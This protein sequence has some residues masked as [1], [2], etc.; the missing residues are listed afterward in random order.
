MK[1]KEYEEGNFGYIGG[2]RYERWPGG[3]AGDK[4]IYGTSDEPIYQTQQINP[5]AYKFDVED[6]KYEVTLRFAEI[7]TEKDAKKLLYNL[8]SDNTKDEAIDRIFN[9]Y[10]NGE[11]AI[12]DL[13]LRKDV[14]EMRPFDVKFRI[15]T[16]NNEG[17]KITFKAKKGDAVINAIQVRKMY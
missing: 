4:E 7:L 13:N 16:E 1:D 5:E 3:P 12:E 11:L 14:G 8:G 6:G 9:V 10:I 2:K 17:I 15:V